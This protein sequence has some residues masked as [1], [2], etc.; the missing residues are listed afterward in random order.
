[1][2]CRLCISGRGFRGVGALALHAAECLV[3]VLQWDRLALG[4]R[5]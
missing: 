1:V 2:L 3:G 4:V 5:A